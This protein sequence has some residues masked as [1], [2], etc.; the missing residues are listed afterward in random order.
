[1]CP[2][3]KQK[4]VLSA[5]VLALGSAI[6]ARAQLIAYEGFDYAPGTQLFGSSG[7]TGWATP[8][9]A[10]SAALSTTP[11]GSLSYSTLPTTGNSV[12][13]GNPVASTA[14]TASSQRL[15]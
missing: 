9:S 5:V 8:W 2:T 12:V 11:S 4:I 6:S 3:L 1:M 15:L 10:T 7:G 14:T 13:M